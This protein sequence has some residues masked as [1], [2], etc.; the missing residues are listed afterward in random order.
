MIFVCHLDI[1]L[2]RAP[3]LVGAKKGAVATVEDIDLWIGKVGVLM[4]IMSTIS[5]TD[6]LGP[7]S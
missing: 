3:S 7:A 1:V 6:M 5:S 2:R 4:S